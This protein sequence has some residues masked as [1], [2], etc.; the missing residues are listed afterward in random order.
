[1]AGLLKRVTKNNKNQPPFPIGQAKRYLKQL[2]LGLALL[3]SPK[4]NILH[5]DIKTA[6]LLINNRGKLQIADFGLARHALPLCQNYDGQ[7]NIRDNAQG[8]K[9]PRMTNLVVTLPYRPPELLLGADHYEKA[10][11]M[12]SAGCIMAEI[13]HG[14]LL[15]FEQLPGPASNEQLAAKHMELICRVLGRPTKENMPSCTGLKL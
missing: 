14:D 11:D 7:E 2:F 12:W 6:N 3:H 9:N 4:L 13:L 15:F 10:V 5:R 1:M 8:R